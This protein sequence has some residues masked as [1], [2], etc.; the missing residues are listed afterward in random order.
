MSDFLIIIFAIL[1]FVAGYFCGTV[2]SYRHILNM[3]ADFN[4]DK[5]SKVTDFNRYDKE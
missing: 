1:A 5:K 3:V 2:S 4:N